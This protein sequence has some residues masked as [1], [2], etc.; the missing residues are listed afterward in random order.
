MSPCAPAT[1]RC[2]LD[3]EVKLASASG[4][5]CCNSRPRTS[6][7]RIFT[8]FRPSKEAAEAAEQ[9]QSY[10]S[11]FQPPRFVRFTA[12]E[13][14]EQ[15]YAYY[16]AKGILEEREKEK[17]MA[18]EL[19]KKQRASPGPKF[20]AR[21]SV[22]QNVQTGVAPSSEGTSVAKNSCAPPLSETVHS[23]QL[24]HS[25]H[26]GNDME[27]LFS[28]LNLL[29]L[30][31]EKHY[32][33]Q[34]RGPDK[35]VQED[36]P[37]TGGP[38][39]AN[40]KGEESQNLMSLQMTSSSLGASCANQMRQINPQKYRKVD[41]VCANNFFA[42]CST[43]TSGA[44]GASAITGTTGDDS[45]INPGTPLISGEEIRN[46]LSKLVEEERQR[47]V[48]A[49][50]RHIRL[51]LQ[52]LCNASREEHKGKWDDGSNG[53]HEVPPP[54]DDVNFDDFI[55]MYE[56]LLDLHFSSTPPE[57]IN[58][59]TG[60]LLESTALQ[61]CT[62]AVTRLVTY[63]LMRSL[64]EELYEG[65]PA[66]YRTLREHTQRTT[67]PSKPNHSQ[68]SGKT[69]SKQLPLSLTFGDRSSAH[70]PHSLRQC[71]R[72]PSPMFAEG[73][74]P[75]RP[76][77]EMRSPTPFDSSRSKEISYF[78]RCDSLSCTRAIQSVALRHGIWLSSTERT[79]KRPPFHACG[80]PLR[81][82]RDI[83]LWQRPPDPQQLNG[84]LTHCPNSKTATLSP[85]TNT[86]NSVMSKTMR[87][88]GAES[89]LLDGG[90]I[91]IMANGEKE[92]CVEAPSWRPRTLAP[93]LIIAYGGY[94][95]APFS[96]PEMSPSTL[97]LKRKVREQKRKSEHV[98]Y[99]RW[100]IKLI[101]SLRAERPE[102]QQAAYLSTIN[103]F[104]YPEPSLLPLHS[105]MQTIYSSVR[106]NQLM[107]MDE[108]SNCIPPVLFELIMDVVESYELFF[109]S[110]ISMS[111]EPMVSRSFFAHTY[112]GMLLSWASVVICEA[113]MRAASERVAVGPTGI[114]WVSSVE[115]WHFTE[116]DLD[117]IALSGLVERTFPSTM[118]EGY[119][120]AV[121]R[122]TFNTLRALVLDT[123]GHVKGE[124]YYLVTGVDNRRGVLALYRERLRQ[125]KVRWAAMQAKEEEQLQARLPGC[126]VPTTDGMANNVIAGE[127]KSAL[128]ECPPKLSPAIRRPGNVLVG[129]L[130]DNSRLP[131]DD[132]GGSR[133]Q[134]ATPL[135][136]PRE[137]SN[138]EGFSFSPSETKLDTTLRS[139]ISASD[140]VNEGSM[141]LVQRSL[142]LGG[143]SSGVSVVQ[144]DPK[145]VGGG[146]QQRCD[147]PQTCVPTSLPKLTQL[148]SHRGRFSLA[149]GRHGCLNASFVYES[150]STRSP[151]D[152][153]QRSHGTKST[154]CVQPAK[155]GV[156]VAPSSAEIPPDLTVRSV[157]RELVALKFRNRQS[158]N[159]A[160]RRRSGSVAGQD[161]AAG[162]ANTLGPS[163]TLGTMIPTPRYGVTSET[164]LT[165]RAP[166][167]SDAT[168]TEKSRASLLLES[169]VGKKQAALVRN[170][171][172]TF[173]NTAQFHL[174]F[175]E[176][177]QER[178]SRH[179]QL[180]SQ[181]YSVGSMD[182]Y[183]KRTVAAIK[184][185][186][187][188]AAFDLHHLSP[189]AALGLCLLRPKSSPSSTG[190][191][192]SH[193]KQ[194]E[195]SKIT[196][197][198]DLLLGREIVPWTI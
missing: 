59:L 160:E 47:R 26:D 65:D 78:L 39:D 73:Y 175:Q 107:H 134:Q 24:S 133:S 117:K 144:A 87:L 131:C 145:V 49:V 174:H 44:D 5:M 25:F 100:Q 71:G 106:Q 182:Y 118:H 169:V 92:R 43:A 151:K 88:I 112:R 28:V 98:K 8:P 21:K 72:T 171:R 129:E 33:R 139:R 90:T 19:E 17:R 137:Q 20:F 138:T 186:R 140:S 31:Y 2:T 108:A 102:S 50:H 189:I 147:G 135:T 183:E 170:M 95:V 150:Q 40:I 177:L 22:V 155:R 37:Q 193:K 7:T 168:D 194:K 64:P 101:A 110:I 91:S 1:A 75:D 46:P 105:V 34:V 36:H 111:F 82:S 136:E 178:A 4:E 84:T 12:K 198:K 68:T 157:R 96:I 126:Q 6:A 18:E 127:A 30:D 3:K 56:S 62:E 35:P 13:R 104:R 124:L 153:P 152:S 190:D 55:G 164:D 197:P 185:I 29:V 158:S 48:E 163:S 192:Q 187:Q 123:M 60:F 130:V 77:T 154:A 51:T 121:L 97:A 115:T 181:W 70:S 156:V 125:E 195:F 116:E 32:N 15:L 167:G 114:S 86:S 94:G 76:G 179:A 85:F 128:S 159:L 54:P 109:Q 81:M 99:K 45:D 180:E 162:A 11:K 149:A 165:P 173:E 161:A 196:L 89:Q 119:D 103:E 142:Q 93:L 61:R 9:K 67:Q 74:E 53:S 143:E 113:A 172:R 38:V 52:N 66:D 23:Q 166:H 148:S 10:V 79:L 191:E 41:T 120:E 42:E 16:V 176:S 58:R 146:L 57:H 141:A 14:H 188:V 122:K 27:K 132:R 80:L 184:R 83:A 63:V 69:S